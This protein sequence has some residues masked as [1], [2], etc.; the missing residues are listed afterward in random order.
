MRISWNPEVI[1]VGQV[2]NLVVLLDKTDEEGDYTFRFA[3]PNDDPFEGGFEVPLKFGQLQDFEPEIQFTTPGT[4]ELQV[5]KGSRASTEGTEPWQ[6]VPIPV[7]AASSAGA[8]PQSVALVAGDPPQSDDEVLWS[9]IRLLTRQLR[10]EEFHQ[11]VE[12]QMTNLPERD[13]FGRQS[14]QTLVRAAERFVEA[15]ADPIRAVEKS[16]LLKHELRPATVLG[17][18]ERS[19]VS[20]ESDALAQPFL[21]EERN[22]GN[23]D[24]GKRPSTALARYRRSKEAGAQFPLPNIPFVELIWSYW[25]EEG[26]LVQTM[27]HIMARFQNRRMARDPLARFDLNPL[28]PLRSL[29]W[30]YTEAERRRL[31]IRR[32]AAEYM[33]QYGLPLVGRAVPPP[34]TLT[35]HRTQFLEGFH[36]LLHDAYRFYKER[37][38]KTVDADAFPLLSSLREVHLVLAHGA[39]NQ[40]ADLPLVAR[41][42]ML[43]MQWILA[44]PEM[45]EF[46]GGPTMV[47]YEE[48]WMDR[49]ETMKTL[50]GWPA[51]SITHFFELAVTGEQIV[52]S[53]RHGRW[54]ESDRTRDHAANW[55][56]T[57]RNEIQR[58]I[59][60]YRA[61]TGVDLATSTDATPPALLLTRRVPQRGR[62]G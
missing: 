50:M 41:A 48:D 62:R 1:R 56:L 13:W 8:P 5:T 28:L 43:E 59:H 60:A 37:D 24:N 30:G 10:F 23:G 6:R 19:Y 16:Q 40:F 39:H 49:V 51:A 57:W 45:R 3:D 35:D 21:D 11:F 27:N 17:A 25:M 15:A 12:A 44:Q 46:L 52:L 54:N 26:A 29:L 31:T 32:R 42:E 33:V 20:S 18:L 2:A 36:A 55:A 38:D 14:H 47:P 7:V 34:D 58:Y 4:K 61:V 53:I 9:F 22:G